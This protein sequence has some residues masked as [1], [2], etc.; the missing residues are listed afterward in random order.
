[1]GTETGKSLSIGAK[2]GIGIG[3]GLSVL[4]V[5][6]FVGDMIWRKRHPPPR[7]DTIPLNDVKA[8]GL[9]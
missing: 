2:V 9:T 1:M 5:G 4:L 7:D 3:I 6:A 8:W